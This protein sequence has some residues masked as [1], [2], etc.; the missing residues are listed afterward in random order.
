MTL[1][2]TKMFFQYDLQ[3]VKRNRPFVQEN[4]FTNIYHVSTTISCDFQPHD[5]FEHIE[6]Y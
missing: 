1:A 5:I 4:I 6:N 3:G 2:G